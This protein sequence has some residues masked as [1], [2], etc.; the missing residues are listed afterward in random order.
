MNEFQNAL[1]DEFPNVSAVNIRRV[2][3]KVMDVINQMSYVLLSMSL[4]G[5]VGV[6]VLAAL[7]NYDGRAR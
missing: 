3:Q 4:V 7:I 6:F 1:V 2:V 5:F